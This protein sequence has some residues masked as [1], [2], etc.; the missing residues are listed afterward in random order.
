[1]RLFYSDLVL[2]LILLASVFRLMFYLVQQRVIAVLQVFSQSFFF[3]N[4][5]LDGGAT[6]QIFRLLLTLYLA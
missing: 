5:F 2:R 3:L 6:E 1:M 4:F